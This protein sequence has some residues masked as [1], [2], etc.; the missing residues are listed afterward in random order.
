MSRL[1]SQESNPVNGSIAPLAARLL[2][3]ASW[4]LNPNSIRVVWTPGHTGLPGNEAAN[5]AARA[6]PI[7]AVAPLCPEAESGNTNL[8]RF[9]EVLAYYRASRRLYPDPA[10]SLEKV[11][12]RLLRHPQANT[13]VNLAVARHFLPDINGT[14]STCQVIA[15]IYRAPR[16]AAPDATA[17]PGVR[18][19]H[20]LANSFSNAFLSPS[21]SFSLWPT[22]LTL[23][24][25]QSTP[26][27]FTR[28]LPHPSALSYRLQ[29]L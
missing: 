12:E 4:R 19:L 8:T 13:F 16:E 25:W 24:A 5:A 22:T 9:R 6:S 2:Q 18:R 27:R 26:I 7:R 23:V 15:D 1:R 20:S 11:D 3:A 17:S 14:C 28:R 21:T 29:T 10:R